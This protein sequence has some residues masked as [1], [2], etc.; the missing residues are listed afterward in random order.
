MEKMVRTQVPLAPEQHE[1]L[2]EI[3]RR[4]GTSLSQIVGAAVKA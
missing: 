4:E 2:A 3:A 1:E